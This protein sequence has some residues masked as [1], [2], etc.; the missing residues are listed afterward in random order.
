MPTGPGGSVKASVPRSFDRGGFLFLADGSCAC[1]LPELTLIHEI[2]LEPCAVGRRPIAFLQ[3][4]QGTPIILIPNLTQG[5]LAV[6]DG[7][8][9][10]VMETITLC[11]QS[12]EEFSFAFWDKPEFY[13]A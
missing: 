7:D 11:K 3:Q 12:I 6:I 5:T 4:Q 8:S 1:R 2:Q 9:H 13:G 10:E